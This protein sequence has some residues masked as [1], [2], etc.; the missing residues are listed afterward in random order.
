MNP[1][2]QVRASRNVTRRAHVEKLKQGAR[3]WGAW[4]EA[5]RAEDPDWRADL[6]EANLAGLDLSHRDLRRA[7]LSGADL[8]G[9]DLTSADLRAAK[10]RGTDLEGATLDLADLRRAHFD[11]ANLSRAELYGAKL[12]G[13]RLLETRVEGTDLREARIGNTYFV[14]VKLDDALGLERVN[15]YDG[16]HLSLGTLTQS[17]GGLPASF[18]RGCGVAPLMQVMLGAERRERVSAFG[19]LRA[20]GFP[21]ELPRRYVMHLFHGWRARLIH[22]AL[23]EHTEFSWHLFNLANDPGLR[24]ESLETAEKHST[25]MLLLNLDRTF[26]G[27]RSVLRRLEK[28]RRRRRLSILWLDV[29]SYWSNFDLAGLVKHRCLDISTGRRWAPEASRR[30]SEGSLQLL[31]KY[32]S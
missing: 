17:G 22:R 8:K 25:V 30:L 4:C 31:L 9:A 16:S 10:L 26:S 15:H 5:L 3:A 2:K 1:K 6:R 12:R 29:T 24:D 28:L 20:G 32:T 11:Q 23:N 21:V 7:I 19:E 27:R 18:L 13:A 14:D